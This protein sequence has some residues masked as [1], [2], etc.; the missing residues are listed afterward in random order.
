[1]SDMKLP[2]GFNP[3]Q[4][5]SKLGKM[6]DKL[7][8]VDL[9]QPTFPQVKIPEIKIPEIEPIPIREHM[10]K[11]EQYQVESLRILESIN[12]NTANL[13]TIIELINKSNEQQDEI[14]TLLTDILAISKAQ[15]KEEASNWYRKAMDKINQTIKDGET[16]AKVVSF[17]TSV[18]MAIQPLLK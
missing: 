2:E 6:M 5:D 8:N 13:Y 15:T 14:I 9:Y 12:Q 7:K 1:V 18:Y 16:L 17:A 3:I 10:E 11:T 4:P